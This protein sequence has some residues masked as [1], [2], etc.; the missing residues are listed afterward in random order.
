MVGAGHLPGMRG[1]W[2]ADIDYAEIVSMP[3]ERPRSRSYN[4]SA[5]TWRRLALVSLS[6]LAL[7]VVVVR[8][9]GRR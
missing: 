2:N 3:Q 7:T 8:W 5:V 1:C 6:G 4:G 9:R